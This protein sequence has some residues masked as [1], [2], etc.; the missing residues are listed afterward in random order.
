MDLFWNWFQSRRDKKDAKN[1][2]NV[3]HPPI[4]S[5]DDSKNTPVISILP[6]PE[7]HLLMGPMNKLYKELENVWPESKL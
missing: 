3:I 6:P 4:L 1:Y 5:D 2:G 7:L